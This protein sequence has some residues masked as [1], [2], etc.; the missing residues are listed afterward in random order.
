MT[1]MKRRF[2]LRS[3]VYLILLDKTKILLS[4]RFKTGWMDGK[5]SL[6]SGHING[7]ESISQAIIRETEEEVGI[8]IHKRDLVPAIALHRKSGGEYADFFFIA[9][10]WK[11]NPK[12]MEPDKCDDLKWCDMDKLPEN[13]LPHVRL[14]IENYKKRVSFF[15]FGW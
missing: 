13:I 7:N 6:I 15:E 8:K 2:T 12:I 14:A 9:K 10:K 1:T 5:Y 4:R 11:G 3:V